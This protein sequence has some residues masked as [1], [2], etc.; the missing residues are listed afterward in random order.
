M[1]VEK[2]S[3]GYRKVYKKRQGAMIF[4]FLVAILA[5]VIASKLVASQNFSRIL[6]VMS[7]LTVLPMA[8]RN[9]KDS[10][11]FR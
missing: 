2:G 10:C 6:I 4:I 9:E 8:R 5:Q 11:V 3:Y 1:K 7:I